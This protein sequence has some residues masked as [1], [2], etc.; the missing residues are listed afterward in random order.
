ML[1]KVAAEKA[2][3]DE[4]E[5]APIPW[6]D[7]ATRLSY[8]DWIAQQLTDDLGVERAVRAMEAMNEAATVH[9]RDDG[10]VQDPASRLVAEAV[11][12][13]PGHRAI[14]LCAAPGGKATL[15]SL[16]GAEVI[17]AD[18]R[19]NRTRLI[20]RNLATLAKTA[21]ASGAP[22]PAW[23]GV[24]TADATAPPFAA[25]SFDRVL[26]DAPCSGLGSLRRRADARWRI[27]A[28]APNRLASLQR[29]ILDAGIELLR[30][31]GE[32]V[33]SVCTL[34]GV[35]TQGVLEHAA[36]RPD[37]EMLP[38]PASPWQTEGALAVL[39]PGET[40]GMALFRL[41]KR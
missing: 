27:D 36:G 32:L 15:L 33:Y 37:I 19:P 21:E 8:P 23:V 35:E 1:R 25:G 22:A 41:R 26:V 17:A 6:P 11:D 20:A 13:Q 9:Q 3:I 16:E 7:D 38:P 31:G 5:A 40:D 2:A 34:T 18:L 28:D 10:Y 24:V 14:D 39:L 12:I 29:S 30:P 4:S